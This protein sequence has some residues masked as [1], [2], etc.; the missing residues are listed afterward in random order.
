MSNRNY[1]FN[2]RSF[3]NNNSK[4]VAVIGNHIQHTN[5]NIEGPTGPAGKDGDRFCTKTILPI[6]FEPKKDGFFALQV[7]IG[8][9]YITGNSVIVAEVVDNFLSDLNSFEGTIHYY[10]SKSGQIII[11]DI[12]NIRGEFGIKEAFYHVNLDGVDGEP[13]VEGPTGP[14]GPSSV[15][16]S[17]TMIELIDNMILLPSQINPISYYTL[18]L[19]NKDEFKNIHAN[20]TN[21]QTA[22]ILINLSDLSDN[23]D[24]IAYIFPILNLNINVNYNS[25]ISLNNVTP[26]AIFKLYNIEN[27]MFSE[28]ITYFKNTYYTNV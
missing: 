28:C 1:M 20:L 16:S 6:L 23:P 12:V 24:T 22:I 21:N 27:L 13:G 5:S 17:S 19:N 9:A 26:F 18:N 4:I 2:L 8:L 25:V 10:N 14:I 3:E 7:D 15:S 11:T